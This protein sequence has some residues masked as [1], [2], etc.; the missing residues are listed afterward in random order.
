MKI[1]S[2]PIILF[3]VFLLASSCENKTQQVEELQARVIGIHDEVMPKMDQ[4][5]KLER[6]I[7][8]IKGDTAHVLAS[9]KITSANNLIMNLENASEN[10]MNWMRNYDST[11]SDMTEEEKINYLKEQ[12][13]SFKQVKQDMLSSISE[14]S[15][16]LE[17]NRA[18]N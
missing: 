10:M 5:M 17:N 15:I 3:C 1:F 16:F 2:Y 14:A 11:M 8:A 13:T 18:I 9:D 7:K 12:E 4:L 6:E